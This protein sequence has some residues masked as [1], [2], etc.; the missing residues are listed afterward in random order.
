MVE[1][2]GVDDRLDEGILAE[3]MQVVGS[4]LL[5]TL[6]ILVLSRLFSPSI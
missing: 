1:Y 5:T 4:Y 3:A 2:T 6:R